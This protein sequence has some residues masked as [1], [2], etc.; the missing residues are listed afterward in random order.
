MW[1]M[2]NTSMW[3]VITENETNGV[4]YGPGGTML[5]LKFPNYKKVHL[6]VKDGG[7]YNVSIVDEDTIKIDGIEYDGVNPLDLFDGEVFEAIIYTKDNVREGKS[8]YIN[9][10]DKNS[11]TTAVVGRITKTEKGKVYVNGEAYRLQDGAKDIAKA[12]IDKLVRLVIKNNKVAEIAYLEPLFANEF[13]V[14]TIKTDKTNNTTYKEATTIGRKSLEIKEDDKVMYVSIDE[15]GDASFAKA[16]DIKQGTVVSEF[17]NS[18][19]LDG[20]LIVISNEKVTGKLEKVEAGRLVI[21]GTAYAADTTISV[22]VGEKEDPTTLTIKSTEFEKYIGE[23]VTITVNYDNKALFMEADEKVVKSNYGFITKVF[24]N[25]SAE[26]PIARV[27]VVG[28]D[29]TATTYDA[30]DFDADK[31]VSCKDERFTNYLTSREVNDEA[32]GEDDKYKDTIKLVQFELK[33][34][35]IDMSKDAGIKETTDTLKALSAVKEVNKTRKTIVNKETIEDKEKDITYVTTSDTVILN[36]GFDEDAKL[37]LNTVKFDD[38]EKELKE[39]VGNKIIVTEKDEVKLDYV[40]IP[41]AIETEEKY[42]IV[43]S[44][45]IAVVEDSKFQATIF[46]VEANDT[47]T[48]EVNGEKVGN[49]KGSVVTYTK[50]ASG[51]Y[52]FKDAKVAD[53]AKLVDDKLFVEAGV[54]Y[55][56][57]NGKGTGVV[58]KDDVVVIMIDEN[59]ELVEDAELSDIDEEYVIYVAE[60]VSTTDNAAKVIIV[61]EK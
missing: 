31:Q 9:A 10:E 11:E 5:E 20:K 35:K 22:K 2:V 57:I 7:K 47:I 30:Y 33:D 46:D 38:V 43:V 29:G 51:M 56:K 12:N 14:D 53:V 28:L 58:V 3:V 50:N 17:N 37:V 49:A 59:G 34:G 27:K 48:V 16:S 6:D 54:G 36:V 25:A 60:E 19:L 1:N 26:E 44:E 55:T 15:K 21:N 4:N 23:Q 32:T 52:T 8:L 61:V 41:S 24:E 18:L 40:I 39:S 42:A 13:V 45:G